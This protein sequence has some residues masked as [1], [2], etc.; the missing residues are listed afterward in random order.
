MSRT[1][2]EIRSYSGV[3]ETHRHDFHQVILPC[4][5][6]LEIDID[7]SAG[8]VTDS[9]A[10]FVPAGFNHA[11]IAKPESRFIVL[12]VPAGLSSAIRNHAAM[13]PFFAI[14]PDIRG[15]IDYLIADGPQSKPSAQLLEMWAGLVLDRLDK[16]G[17][18]IDLT[19]L[20]VNRAIAFMK[21]RLAQPIRNSDIAEA[22][23]L[24]PTR[25]HDAFLKRLAMTPHAKL[26]AIRLDAAESLLSNP[27]LSIAEVALRSGHS[28]QSAL[29]RIM[30]RERG[31]TPA[32]IRKSLLG[33]FEQKA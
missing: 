30:Q 9:I 4:S 3:T 28:D 6:M 27:H 31:V 29:T 26:I 19:E 14:R 5:G 12:D 13:A 18:N 21:Q 8:R 10:S 16:Q 24:S 15:L 17:G 20:A 11:F 23:R 7:R 22:A 25:L 1:V 32:A 2:V 33:R